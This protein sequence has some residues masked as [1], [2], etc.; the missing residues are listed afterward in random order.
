MD[1]LRPVMT[2]KTIHI[3]GGGVAGLGLAWRLAIA[4]MRVTVFD[5]GA[6][7]RGASWAA[8][9]MLA[10]VIEAEPGEDALIPFVLKSQSMW[11]DFAAELQAYTGQDVGYRESGTLFVAAERDD[12][13]LLKQRFDF[14]KARNLP[15]EWLERSE[16]RKREPYFSPRVTHGF[17]SAQDHQVDNRA[18]VDA[19]HAAC[20]KAGVELHANA[21]VSEIKISNGKATHIV[22]NDGIIA[23]ENLV[24]AAGAWSG[25]IK[26][27]PLEALPPVFPMKG[28]LLAVQ[29]DARQPLLKHVVWTPQVYLV[30]RSDGRLIVGAT[31][32]D[33]G[34]DASL[35]AGG[36]LHLLRETWEALPGIEELPLLETWAGFRPTSRDDAPILGESA[37][38]NLSFMT[39]QHRHGILMTPLL[40]A[41]MSE[42]ILKGALPDVAAPFTMQR[43][44]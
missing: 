40:A 43:F 44:K 34:F 17:Y 9:G 29:M 13:G 24:L 26:G 11:P 8:A 22:I 6:I 18:L 28:Q 30:P 15:V 27:L 33:K 16:L 21:D 36:I 3:I 19:L 2:Q 12:E 37:I 32:E 39:G 4:G 10:A 31:L 7:G 20:K 5:K 42:Y 23:V 35:T 41:A 25:S 14:L 38:K 1:I